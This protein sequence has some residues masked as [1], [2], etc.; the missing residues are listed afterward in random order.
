MS[1]NT[2]RNTKHNACTRPP[3]SMYLV[4]EA[5]DGFFEGL[6]SQF[7]VGHTGL[8]LY[9]S[10]QHAQLGRRYVGPTCTGGGVGGVK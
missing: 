4:N 3:S 2:L 9:L 10:L 8:V 7:L 1:E 6:P 5:I